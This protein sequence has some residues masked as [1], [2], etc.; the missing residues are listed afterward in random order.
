MTGAAVRAG[1]TCGLVFPGPW[2]LA[3]HLLEAF[4]PKA[5][6]PPD[7]QRHADATRLAVKVGSTTAAWEVVTWAGNRRKDL[8]VAAAIA[9]TIRA[10]DLTRHQEVP[11]KEIHDSYGVSLDVAGAAV[12][13]LQD[14]G[15]VGNYGDRC[16]VSDGDIEDILNR[17]SNGTMLDQ[18]TRHVAALEDRMT[19]LED[20]TPAVQGKD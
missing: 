11:R 6:V 2:E 12:G 18:I 16:N 10:G 5:A 3:A 14:F 15:I 7:G 1:C 9:C 17:Y 4:P 19:M 13:I 20:Q 8:R